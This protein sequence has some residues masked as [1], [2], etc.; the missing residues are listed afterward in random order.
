MPD[1]E[2]PPC[3]FCGAVRHGRAQSSCRVLEPPPARVAAESE[4]APLFG[5]YEPAGAAAEWSE[6]DGTA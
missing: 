3:G 6:R 5:D 4:P 2:P 1:R